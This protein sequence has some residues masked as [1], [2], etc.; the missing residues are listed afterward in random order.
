MRFMVSGPVL[1]HVRLFLLSVTA[2]KLANR[3][4]DRLRFRSVALVW[5]P[6][7]LPIGAGG[8]HFAIGTAGR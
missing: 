1:D 8:E 3:K 6:A 7:S 4:P 2:R 5:P